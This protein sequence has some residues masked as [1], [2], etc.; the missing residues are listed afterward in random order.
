MSERA[1]GTYAARPGP[2]GP[3]SG[4]LERF[5][6]SSGVPATVGG[7]AASELAAVFAALDQLEREAEELRGRLGAA[8]AQREHEIEEE[9]QRI[10][11]EAR[12]RAE[13]ERDDVLKV[14]LRAVD[15]EIAGIVT[16]AE[17]DARRI[18]KAGE[19]RLPGFVA[20]VLTRVHEATS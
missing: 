18:S 1:S 11:V 7:D 5:R 20:E 16:Q 13:S 6:R 4:F 19:E 9:A 8:A 15:A 14:R 12:R 17:A 10:V 2:L 3:L